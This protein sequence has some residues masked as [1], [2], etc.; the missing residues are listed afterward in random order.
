MA[1][2]RISTTVDETLLQHARDTGAGAN[3]AELID[4][5]LAALLAK[6]R[7]V[8]IDEHYTAAYT[9]HPPDEADDWGDLSTF[10]DAASA[11]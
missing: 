4:A 3:D 9:E 10:R 11:T 7:R 6:Y 5:A 1:R 2:T 8:E